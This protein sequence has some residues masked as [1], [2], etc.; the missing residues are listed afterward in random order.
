MIFPIFP[1]STGAFYWRWRAKRARQGGV[2]TRQTL[3][4]YWRAW[5][6]SQR[7]DDLLAF[8][9]FR[10]DLG[11]PAQRFWLKRLHNLV[12]DLRPSRRLLYRALAQESWGDACRGW[13]SQSLP[14]LNFAQVQLPA[15]LHQVMESTL[16]A[17]Q[18]R[19]RD[20]FRQQTE[21]RQTLRAQLRQ[22][23]SAGG[24]CVLGNAGILHQAGLGE[25]IDRHAAVLRFNTYQSEHTTIIDTGS[26]IQLWGITGSYRINSID[27]IPAVAGVLLAGPAMQF[28]LLD[29]SGLL[30]LRQ[31]GLPVITLPLSLWHKLV[32]VL[33]APPSA[34]LL[35]LAF[36]RESLGSW[37]GISVAGFSALVKQ[38][39]KP[40]HIS[41]PKHKASIRHNW[42]AEKQL[43]QAW[44]AE[45]LHSLHDE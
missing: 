25:R 14:A 16:S 45:G 20:V 32:K 29:C 9:L 5:T 12:G 40:Y 17:D 44:L 41:H 43:L 24:I 21:W 35:C 36:L 3:Y 22:W 38:S 18:L 19:L 34:G 4:Y 42:D 7:A 37:Q 1:I 23:Q 8:L 39:D 13:L 6:C 15:V 10:R 2:Y 11:L 27:H 33:Q 31:A 26:T 30:S 28:R